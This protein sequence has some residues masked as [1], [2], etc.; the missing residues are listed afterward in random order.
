[1]YAD[2][3]EGRPPTKKYWVPFIW[4]GKGGEFQSQN[5]VVAVA[6]AVAVAVAVVLLVA[7]AVVLLIVVAVAVVLLVAVAAVAVVLLVAVA[8]AV[9]VVLY[10]DEAVL[11]RLPGQVR[12]LAEGVA[13]RVE[14]LRRLQVVAAA[15]AT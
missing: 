14:D 6:G 2:A 5:V 15:P 10:L 1:M 8:V 4:G 3:S 9:S 13:L 7:V 11:R 12:P